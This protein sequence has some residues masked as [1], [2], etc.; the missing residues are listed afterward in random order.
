M[1]CVRVCVF[2]CVCVWGGGVKCDDSIVI[3]YLC[4]DGGRLVQ[5]LMRADILFGGV[6]VVAVG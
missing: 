3:E 5:M 6:A 1:L 4:E 2:V